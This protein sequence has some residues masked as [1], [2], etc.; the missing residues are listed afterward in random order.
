MHSPVRVLG[1]HSSCVFFLKVL[2]IVCH[3]SLATAEANRKFSAAA[4][5]SVEAAEAQ[6]EVEAATNLARAIGVST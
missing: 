3:H 6:I 5:D 2:T 4:P 1:A